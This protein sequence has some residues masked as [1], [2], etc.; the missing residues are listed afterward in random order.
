MVPI[1]SISHL[2]TLPFLIF[3]V[4]RL[5]L[6]FRKNKDKNTGYFFFSFIFLTIMEGVLASP[7][8]VFNDLI[9][10]STVFAF[11]PFLLFLAIGF[12]GIT[13]FSISKWERSEKIFLLMI[14]I[15][16]VSVTVINLSNVREALSYRYPPFAYW[17]DTRGSTMNIFIGGTGALILLFVIYFFLSRGISSS[18]KRIR[19]R[20]FLIAGGVVSFFLASLI[21]FV[22]GALNQ[23]YFTSFISTVLLILGSMLIFS[24]TGYK[25][26]PKE[27]SLPEIGEEEYSKIQW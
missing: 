1:V 15:M 14:V 19:I 21:N 4:F 2:I 6:A 27:V 23:R 22:F 12:L 26:K 5:Y 17:E 24:A 10:I 11:Y 25:E 13:P 18:E 9:K 16:A 8:L 7:G 3:I 20:S